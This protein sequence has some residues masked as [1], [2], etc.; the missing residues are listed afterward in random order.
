MTQQMA[1]IRGGRYPWSMTW[2]Q[3]TS[4]QRRGTDASTAR[5][6]WWLLSVHLPRGKVVIICMST[7]RQS[8]GLGVPTT[9]LWPN[10]FRGFF[11]PKFEP[12]FLLFALAFFWCLFSCLLCLLPIAPC[13]P[14]A[15]RLPPTYRPA[16]ASCRPATAS[17]HRL[18]PPCYHLLPPP[19]S[20][21]P[22]RVPTRPKNS[23]C[24]Y[25]CLPE[26]RLCRNLLLLLACYL[27][28]AAPC[29]LLACLLA[30]LD[31]ILAA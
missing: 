7:S 2:L 28:A 16:A 23:A 22:A 31:R 19:C 12:C 26:N 24:S 13:L 21:L 27:L 5:R 9:R 20:L 18:L 11:P 3:Q 25:S 10:S 15:T 29:F 30:V 14:V 17:C 1:R 8:R 4:R 6:I